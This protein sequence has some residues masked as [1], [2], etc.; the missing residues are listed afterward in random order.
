[1]TIF[2]IRGNRWRLFWCG[3]G[4]L[5]WWRRANYLP[6]VAGFKPE[7]GNPHGGSSVQLPGRYSLICECGRGH[8][9]FPRGGETQ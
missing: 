3:C 1:M 2:T 7:P 8:V 6:P 4:R 9:M 5:K